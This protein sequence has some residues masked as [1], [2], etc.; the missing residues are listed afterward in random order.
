MSLE[1]AKI[2]PEGRLRRGFLPMPP[3]PRR[4]R[5]GHVTNFDRSRHGSDTRHNEVELWAGER[6]RETERDRERQREA[7]TGRERP[8]RGREAERERQRDRE[9]QRETDRDIKPT[10]L[11]RGTKFSYLKRGAFFLLIHK[12]CPNFWRV[13]HLCLK[14]DIWRRP[15]TPPPHPRDHTVSRNDVISKQIPL[16]SW[17]FS[18][19]FFVSK[20]AYF[21]RLPSGKTTVS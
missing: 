14:V 19:S 5:E 7:E 12:G 18:F 2:P 20:R 17:M 15:P 4:D 1:A 13:Q 3:T 8:R 21:F 10:D 16:G 11:Q 9:K 6:Q